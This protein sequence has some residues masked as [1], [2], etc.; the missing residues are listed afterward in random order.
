MV[1]AGWD[2]A[3]TGKANIYVWD[4]RSAAPIL[5]IPTSS[6]GQGHEDVINMVTLTKDDS[7]IV[8]CR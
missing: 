4:L 6:A 7:R 1:S 3:D 5:K 2:G 8:S